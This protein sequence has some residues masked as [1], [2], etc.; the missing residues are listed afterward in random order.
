MTPVVWRIRS[1]GAARWY[2]QFDFI[3]VLMR[4][5]GYLAPVA[6]SPKQ[7]QTSGFGVPGWALLE[8]PPASISVGVFA[9][10]MLGCG[11]FDGLNETFWWLGVI[12]VNPLDFQGRSSIVLE[13]I[14]GLLSANVLL[15]LVFTGCVYLGIR[16]SKSAHH[17][18]PF[19][20]HFSRLALCL[21]PIAF[22]Y[23]VAHYIAAYLVNIQ[24]TIA[25]ISDPFNR[26]DDWLG[27]GQ[28]YVTT[29]FLNNH[30]TVEILWLF[31]A[32]VVV[33]GH[34]MS[35][36]LAHGVAID[37]HPNRRAALLSQ[38]PL[39]IFMIAYTFLGLWL[40]ASPRGA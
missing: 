24:Y 38:L 40:L 1:V 29:G 20:E 22:A 19:S 12:G 9:L 28:F 18:A 23:H 21:L 27:L 11:S 39:V 3:A 26:G 7:P 34:V 33:F 5:Y 16:L 13:T 8:H 31:Q 36:L 2:A 6:R 35:I 10:V 37:L 25:A 14:A 32:G 4:L 15:I 17:A 30:H